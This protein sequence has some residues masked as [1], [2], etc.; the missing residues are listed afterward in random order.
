MDSIQKI[1]KTAYETLQ[2]S[3]VEIVIIHYYQTISSNSHGDP[4][5]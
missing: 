5:P 3:Y 2:E 4:R 1:K